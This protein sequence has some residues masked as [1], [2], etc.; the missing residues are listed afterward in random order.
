MSSEP[1]PSQAGKGHR[2][3]GAGRNKPRPSL[4]PDTKAVKAEFGETYDPAKSFNLVVCGATNPT[5]DGFIFGDFFGLCMA[6]KQ[7]NVA[8]EF[9]SCFPLE[10]HF[11]ELGKRDPP[12]TDLKYGKFGPAR[13]QALWTYTKFDFEH[14]ERWWTQIGPKSLK[15]DLLRWIMEKAYQARSGDVVNIVL[16]C[17]GA[18]GG[19]IRLGDHR[20]WPVDFIVALRA[21]RDE[22]HVNIITGACYGGM[23][24]NAMRAEGQFYRYVQ[25][26]ESTDS[27]AYGQSR[28]VSRR[29]R[30]SRFSQAFCMS[31]AKMDFPGLSSSTSVGTNY[32]VLDHENFVKEQIIRNITPNYTATLPLSY[33]GDPAN[34]Q[35]I[36]RTMFFRD[37]VDIL[38]NP[39]ATHRRRRIEWPD[40]N[41]NFRQL[42]QAHKPPT[43]PAGDTMGKVKGMLDDEF[44]K[45][46]NEQGFPDDI[47]ATDYYFHTKHNDD[48]TPVLK[49][50]YWRGRIQSTIFDV[51]VQLCMR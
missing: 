4:G 39:A 21:F 14:R 2:N 50:M 23:F 46:D 42:I 9:W 51:F 15:D 36:M 3:S 26:A 1:G 41:L 49:L 45:C 37:S 5:R 20:L 47:G 11:E 32:R 22:V 44:S 35:N 48:F 12:I 8:G 43:R 25:A 10:E 31:L 16:E 33:F 27:L 24:V 28:S 30:N 34:L 6:F 13:D 17:H 40:M 38:Y 18:M 29:T 19:A 7:K